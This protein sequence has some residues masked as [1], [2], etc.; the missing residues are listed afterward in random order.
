MEKIEVQI[1]SDIPHVT[2]ILCGF[3]ELKR[4]EKYDVSF[5][6]LLSS[7][8]YFGYAEMSVVR[9]VYRGKVIIYDLLDGYLGVDRMTKLLI[10]CDLY[11]KRSFSEQKNAD[12]SSELKSKIHPLGFNYHLT[13]KGCPL[14]DSLPK[15]II[16]T[17]FGRESMN[18]FT[19]D[20]FEGKA[21]ET[22]GKPEILFLTRLWDP[23]ECSEEHKAERIKINSDRISI[24]KALKERYGDNAT[25]G[26]NDTPFSRSVAPDLIMDDSF[27]K[28]KN[29]LKLL[30][31]SDICIASTGLHGSI[32]WKTG[33]YVAAAKAIV[34]E[35][36]VYTVTGDFEEGKNY[37]SYTTPEQ[38]IAAVDSLWNDPK[39]IYEMKINNERYYSKYLSPAAIVENTLKITDTIIEKGY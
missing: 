16:K 8:E 1:I 7:S 10:G 19:A 37:L 3:N 38:C 4:S 9:V 12:F 27:T 18:S 36:F 17:L 11:F 6:N 28:R 20:R 34:S 35:P 15:R 23:S 32:G 29:Y 22:Q 25:V 39:A 30:H 5:K 33:E 24:I 26:I 31:K 14:N 21:K 13:Y 2:Q